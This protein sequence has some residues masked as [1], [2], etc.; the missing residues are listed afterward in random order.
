MLISDH[1]LGLDRGDAVMIEVFID[2]HCAI[3]YILLNSGI[4]RLWPNLAP[5][6]STAVH[7][8]TAWQHLP[9]SFKSDRVLGCKN[10]FAAVVLF[11]VENLI[12][13]GGLSKGHTVTDDGIRV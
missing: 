7:V 4:Y 2:D 3:T 6:V 5:Y 1:A 9:I 8:R 11:L 13:S 12:G 10:N